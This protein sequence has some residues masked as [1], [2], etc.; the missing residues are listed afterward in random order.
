MCYTGDL[1]FTPLNSAKVQTF[2]VAKDPGLA[3]LRDN[4]GRLVNTEL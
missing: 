1:P 2:V 3:S 4:V